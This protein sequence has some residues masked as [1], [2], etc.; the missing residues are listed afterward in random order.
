LLLVLFRPSYFLLFAIVIASP[1]QAGEAISF[2]K[3]V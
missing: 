1:P 2:V 3:N